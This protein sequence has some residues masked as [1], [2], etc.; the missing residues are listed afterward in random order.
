M[1]KNPTQIVLGAMGFRGTP[2]LINNMTNNWFRIKK[3]HH[4][5]YAI[6][7][8][9]HW[10]KVISYL[11]IDK[12]GAFLIDTG[13]GYRSIKK[14]VEKR[15]SLPVRVLLTHSH[16][17]HI[18][19]VHEF[20]NTSVFDNTFEKRNLKNG[21]WAA[22]VP[23]LRDKKMFFKGFLPRNYYSQGLCKFKL[24]KNFQTIASDT[25]TINVIHTPGHTPGSVC[26][27]IPEFNALFTGD[28][29]YP[30]PLYCQLPESNIYDYAQSIKL[31]KKEFPNKLLILPGHNSVLAQSSLLDEA[32]KL[33][34][35]LETKQKIR[36]VTEVKGKLLS[37]KLSN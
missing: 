2:F 16:W 20:P 18:G 11:I 4:R 7:E 35:C 24:L 37:L 25:F 17:D 5:I 22:K 26:F 34:S 8:F 27:F 14:E 21:F 1:G 9:F 29:L 19:G 33:F 36:S 10:E 30:G 6:T 23:E 32:I 12:N 15:T 3:V 31:L 13:M 28:T